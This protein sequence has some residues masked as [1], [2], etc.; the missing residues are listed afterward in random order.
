MELENEAHVL[1]AKGRTLGVAEIH[2]VDPVNDNTAAVG[3]V[4][5]SH[6]LK[7]RRLTRS[8]SAN[9][10]DYPASFNVKINAFQHFERAE[11]LLYTSY[12]NHFKTF[13]PL[14]MLIPF[15]G[16]ASR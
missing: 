14:I 3:F 12:L 7:K 2:Y 10:A 5:R 16:L 4:E 8:T 13:L 9:Y 15:C 6:Y 1:V 11:T